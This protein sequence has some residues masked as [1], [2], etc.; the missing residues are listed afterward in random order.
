MC[1]LTSAD[2]S[3][4]LRVAEINNAEESK[5]EPTFDARKLREIIDNDFARMDVV[6]NERNAF[7]RSIP[8]QDRDTCKAEASRANDTVRTVRPELCFFLWNKTRLRRRTS[9]VKSEPT[10]CIDTNSASIATNV[11]GLGNSSKRKHSCL[12]KR[13]SRFLCHISTK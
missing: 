9:R 7:F 11:P 2:P 5:K 10:C 13:L 3:L 8:S 6:V 12:I 4:R 1:A